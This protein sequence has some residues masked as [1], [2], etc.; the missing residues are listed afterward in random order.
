[1]NKRASQ[2]AQW[3]FATACALLGVGILL[4]QFFP[5]ARTWGFH[6]LS[7]YSWAAKSG[8]I[9]AGLLAAAGI[10]TRRKSSAFLDP[11][12]P[13]ASSSVLNDVLIAALF[14]VIFYLFRA[15]APVLGDGQ[16]WINELGEGSVPFWHRRGPLTLAL[17]DLLYTWWKSG[18]GI[19]PELVFAVSAALAGA[20]T[21]FAWLRVGRSLQVGIPVVLLIGFQWGGIAQFFGYAELYAV[22]IAMMSVG[23]ALMLTGL[24]RGK[25]NVAVPILGLAAPFF[26]LIAVTFLPAIAAYTWWGITRRTPSVKLVTSAVAALLGIAALVYVFSGWYK[27]TD[28]LLPLW[29]RPDWSYA[30]L[31]LTHLLDLA[32]GLALVIGPAIGIL[33]GGW[34]LHRFAQPTAR[35][36]PAILTLA[37]GVPLA[38]YFMH[39]PQLGMARDW[40]IGAALLCAIPFALLFFWTEISAHRRFARVMVAVF[41]FWLC[42][43]TL[44]W[45]GVQASETRS[46]ARFENLLHLDRDKSAT[47]WDYLAAYWGRRNK[48]DKVAQCYTEAVKVSPNVR[49]RRALAVC[50]ASQRDWANAKREATAV[51]GVVFADSIVTSWE[52]KLIDFRPFLQAAGRFLELGDLDN[53]HQMYQLAVILNPQSDVP[54]L[55]IGGL[56]VCAGQ[57]ERAEGVFRT[58][59]NRDS[60]LSTAAQS[61]FVVLGEQSGRKVEGTLGLGMLARV[62]GDLG[63]AERK[64]SE[65]YELSGGNQKIGE[66]LQKI[67]K[68]P[69]MKDEG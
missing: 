58:L 59:L 53:A 16:L 48:L 36:E 22:M 54:R 31:S 20:V 61:F 65:A 27:G 55:A 45:L 42:V 69:S 63:E 7:Y 2:T 44:P 21:V 37:A 62:R 52:A 49:Y 43:Q 67:R 57:F 60:T 64:V 26:H 3:A 35:P 30:A 5:Q 66:Y 17:Y 18:G 41:A 39:N 40:D 10:I 51:A 13:P 23:F 12:S 68:Q 8:F 11:A 38:A 29:P 56:L 14:G 9:A 34:I 4:G 1:M 19:G 25:F 15:A 24:R 28:I 47:G 32:N 46:I 33:I 50:Y 6:F